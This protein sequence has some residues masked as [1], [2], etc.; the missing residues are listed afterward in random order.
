VIDE[1]PYIFTGAFATRS[2]VKPNVKTGPVSL[3]DGIYPGDTDPLSWD[4][5]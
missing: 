2:L 5:N 3:F 4:I 1:S